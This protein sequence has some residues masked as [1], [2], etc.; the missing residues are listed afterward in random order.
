MA[1][2][3][4]YY[5]YEYDVFLCFRRGVHLAFI[6]YLYKALD[7]IGIKTFK[8]ADK[9]ESPTDKE[10]TSP[11]VVEKIERSRM[12]VVVF[13]KDFPYSRRC[14]DEV[15]KIKE[16]SDDNKKR[17]QM[18]VVPI[19]YYGV[20]PADVRWQRK[21]TTY[22]EAFSQHEERLG[23]DSEKIE[24]WR[25]ALRGLCQLIGIECHKNAILSPHQSPSSDPALGL[26]Q[27]LPL[28]RNI[29]SLSFS[30]STS[31]HD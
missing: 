18:Q 29:F 26:F 8:D 10:E 16:C 30:L 23:K 31:S 22:G 28:G 4:S 12:S 6:D 14:L 25:S 3:G 5:T 7:G 27:V 19:F 11:D 21:E 15:A 24:T 9:E 1:N 13:C 20:E 2:H 17:M